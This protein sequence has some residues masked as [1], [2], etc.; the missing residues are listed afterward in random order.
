MPELQKY[1]KW[2][3]IISLWQTPYVNVDT[4]HKKRYKRHTPEKE[5][6]E[7]NKQV[8]RYLP[9]VKKESTDTILTTIKLLA[10]RQ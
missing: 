9:N 7:K 1:K 6:I 10:S 3:D 4:A 2:E 8:I 5:I